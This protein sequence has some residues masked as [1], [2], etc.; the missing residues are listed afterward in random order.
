MKA[1][2]SALIV[3]DWVVV[4]ITCGKFLLV[5]TVPFISNFAVKGSASAYGT[6]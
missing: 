6:I 2:M 3:S 5:L 4:D 1:N